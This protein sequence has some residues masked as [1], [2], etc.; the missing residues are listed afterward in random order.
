MAGVVSLW[1]PTGVHNSTS[2]SSGHNKNMI[3]DES[4]SSTST[5]SSNTLL[6]KTQMLELC[7][8]TYRKY[9]EQ[10]NDM[11][12][13]LR[14]TGAAT[15]KSST[16]ASRGAAG[17]VHAPPK[18]PDDIW[19]DHMKDLERFKLFHGHCRVPRHFLENPKLGRWVMNVRAHYQMLQK[20][21]KSSLITR[22][23]LEQLQ[24]IDFDFAPKNKSHTKYYVDRWTLHLQELQQFKK[25]NGHCRVPQRYKK[26]RKLGGWVLYVRH[27]YRKLQSGHPSTMTPDRVVQLKLLGFDFDPRKGR[28]GR[29]DSVSL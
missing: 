11:A 15:T 4:R 16:V 17:V 14:S 22:D 8:D 19:G 23:R 3:M 28:P 29:S 24:E 20:G 9:V 5:T 10:R 7:R 21:K 6:Q 25:Q 2:T 27:Q 13:Y 18:S 1:L 26:N 12:A